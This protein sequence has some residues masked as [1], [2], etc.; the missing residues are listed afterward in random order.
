MYLFLLQLP[1]LCLMF[2]WSY[3]LMFDTMTNVFNTDM[4]TDTWQQQCLA[5]MLE[6]SDVDVLSS[7]FHNRHTKYR[8]QSK[9]CS[10]EMRSLTWWESTFQTMSLWSTEAEMTNWSETIDKPTKQH[11]HHQSFGWQAERQININWKMSKD[12]VGYVLHSGAILWSAVRFWHF[13]DLCGLLGPEIFGSN[14][15]YPNP[16]SFARE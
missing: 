12:V 9:L 11:R 6:I 15:R 2:V 4:E 7:R 13:H 5:L 1:K 8:N 14:N 16:T 3:C 10:D